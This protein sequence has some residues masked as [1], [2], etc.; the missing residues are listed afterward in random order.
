MRCLLGNGNL[1]IRCGCEGQGPRD[2]AQALAPC[3]GWGGRQESGRFGPLHGW[4]SR[5]G[6][7]A[8]GGLPA[9]VNTHSAGTGRCQKTF[10][11]LACS[12]VCFQREPPFPL[13]PRDVS[14]GRKHAC[15]AACR[16]VKGLTETPISVIAAIRDG[17][18][19]RPV[20]K[21]RALQVR[22][23]QVKGSLSAAKK[24]YQY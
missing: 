11:L 4:F 9:G 21:G 6:C 22:L 23:N 18:T 20:G 1:A 8:A 12:C 13:S 19:A 16:A 24:A 15:K 14:T 10:D 5:A 7:G 17:G 2:N 3:H